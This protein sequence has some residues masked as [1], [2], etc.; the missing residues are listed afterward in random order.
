MSLALLLDEVVLGNVYLV[1]KDITW[2]VNHLH[3]V[4]QGCRYIL[5]VVSRGYA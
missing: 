2:N 5:N 4:A 3:T 1:L